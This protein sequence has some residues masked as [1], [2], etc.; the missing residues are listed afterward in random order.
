MKKM[1]KVNFQP[2]LKAEEDT[3]SKAL[4]EFINSMGDYTAARAMQANEISRQAQAAQMAFNAQQANLANSITDNR[5]ASQYQFNSA[6]A[7][8]AN[9][10]TQGM[11][12]QTADWNEAMWEKQAAFNAEQAQI[13]REW[14]ERMENTKYQRAINDMSKAGLNPILAVTGGGIS[15]GAGSGAAASVGGATMGSGGMAGAA[16]GSASNYSGIMDQSSGMLG[17]LGMLF[18]S[19]SSASSA[20]GELGSVG[21][22]VGE[23]F[24]EMLTDNKSAAETWKNLPWNEWAAEKGKETR[25][26]IKGLFH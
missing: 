24:G 7:S 8:A 22:Q 13:Q 18:N 2:V 21:E 19:L 12:Q 9:Q 15:T 14:S 25:E 5:L 16:A 1:A 10:F 26:K 20:I 3:M 11:W 4:G 6:Q 23:A 17:M